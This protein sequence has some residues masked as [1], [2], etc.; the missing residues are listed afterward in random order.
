MVEEIILEYLHENLPE[1]IE[2]YM[3]HPE[4]EDPKKMVVVEKTSSTEH[5]LVETSMLAIQSYGP[6][7]YEAAQLN[8]IVKRLMREA[9]KL[10][11]VSACKINTDYNYTNPATKE[12]RYQAVFDVVTHI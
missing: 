2:A 6:T 5:D 8:E 11:G 7:L 10:T 3:E 12:Y 9:V 4:G 1:G